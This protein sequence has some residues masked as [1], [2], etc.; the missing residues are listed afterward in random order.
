[1]AL[2]GDEFE[3]P[4]AEM[5]LKITPDADEFLCIHPNCLLEVA[6][7]YYPRFRISTTLSRQLK[8]P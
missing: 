6:K 5:C 2:S 1:M 3:D 8:N 4:F 7:S